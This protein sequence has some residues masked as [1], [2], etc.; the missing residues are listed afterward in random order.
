MKNSTFKQ[1]TVAAALGLLL[2]VASSLQAAIVFQDSFTNFTLGGQWEAYGAGA[3]DIALSLV[4]V[5]TDGSSLRMGASPGA[6]GEVVGIRTVASFPIEGMRS[7]RVTA[8]LRPLNQT[9]SGDGGA[10]IGGIDANGNTANTNLNYT[11]APLTVQVGPGQS[12][13]VEF[14][15]LPIPLLSW[16]QFYYPVASDYTSVANSDTDGD[17]MTA[18]AEYAAGTNPTNRSSALRIVVYRHEAGSATLSW[19]G[20]TNRL[21]AIWH[22]TN[23][24][25]G[26]ALLTNG[27]QGLPAGTNNLEFAEPADSATFYRVRASIPP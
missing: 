27:V 21:Y 14:T 2:G 10:R 15:F 19:V 5:G 20:I 26:W 8:R 4:G 3:P 6:G 17:G 22:S 11:G 18:G 13:Y 24:L 7:V 1:S 16:L 12:V 25:N 23:L 9:G